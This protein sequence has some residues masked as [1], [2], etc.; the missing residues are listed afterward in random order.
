MKKYIKALG[1]IALGVIFSV[2]FLNFDDNKDFEL[3]KNLDIYYSL[4]KELNNYYVDEIDPGKLVKTS[5]DNMLETLDPYT[6]Y[7]PESKMEDY[8]FMTTGQYG[9]IGAMISNFDGIITVTEIYK[10]F[11][12]NKYGLKV[13]DKILSVDGI[14]TSGKNTDQISELLK[15]Q[16]GTSADIEIERPTKEG[17]T[18]MIINVVREK[19]K[20]NSVPYFGFVDDKIGYIS[21]SSFTETAGSEVKSALKSLVDQGAEGIVLDLR[22]NPGGLLIESVKITNLFVDKGELVVYTKGKYEKFDNRYATTAAPV[23]KELPLAVLVNSHSAS[24]SEIVSGA[25]QDMDRAV[26]VGNRTFGKGLVQTTREL[27]YNTKL[28]V[29]TAKYYIPSGRCIQALDYSHRNSDG[30]VGKVPDSLITEFATSNGRKVFDGGGVQPDIIVEEELSNSF[31]G[32]L[33]KKNM[34]FDYVTQYCI[35]HPEIAEPDKFI[36]DSVMFDDFITF[37][38]IQQYK[39]DYSSLSKLK[40]VEDL[41]EKEGNLQSVKSMLD[42]VV[43]AVEKDWQKE[44]HKNKDLISSLLRSEIVAR[45]Y[46][47]EGAIISQLKEDVQ[48]KRS[49]EILKNS[50]EYLAILNGQKGEHKKN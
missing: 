7:I 43:S 25:L 13:G 32:D 4:F 26:V 38:E 48:L 46:F 24:A 1:F 40:T 30:S 37:C 49:V 6:N 3:S 31:V 23:A 10:D 15:G 22:G 17:S 36:F 41:L 42:S 35:A 50:E 14:A 20:I 47:Q 29:T 34:L 28:K 11:P 18:K 8:K 19:V 39:Y 16:P 45:S 2:A 9:G 5:I 21:L 33:I 44:F 12:A 27:T